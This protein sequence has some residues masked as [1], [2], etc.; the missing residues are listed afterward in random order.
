MAMTRSFFI[1]FRNVL[2]AALLGMACMAQAQLLQP[3]FST[4]FPPIPVGDYRTLSVGVRNPNTRTAW[5]VDFS[6]S[7]A[8]PDP[9]AGTF[10][11]SG[12]CGSS[13]A[14]GGSS[15]VV[16]NMNVLANGF[17]TL[18]FLATGSAAGHYP[19]DILVSNP[20]GV[21]V[22]TEYV[23]VYA[24]PT[25]IAAFSSSPVQVNATSTLTFTIS[26]TDPIHNLSV[27]GSIGLGALVA[28]TV[29]TTCTNLDSDP[30]IDA[31]NNNLIIPYI[32]LATQASCDVS[33]EVRSDTSGSYTVPAGG[34]TSPTLTGTMTSPLVIE[35]GFS[36]AFDISTVTLV[37]NPPAEAIGVTKSFASS[38]VPVG[39]PSTLTIALTN[40]N[41][42]PITGVAFTDSLP[43]GL[44]VATVPSLT[45]TCGGTVTAGP[46][47]TS[48]VLSG[49]TIAAADPP[50]PAAR[51]KAAKALGGCTV[52]IAV[53]ASVPSAGLVN[54]LPAG[55]VTSVE[56]QASGVLSA[57]SSATLVVTA[58]PAVLL[59]PASLSFAQ[60]LL[61][62]TSAVQAVTLTN[63]GS[64]ALAISAIAISGDFAQSNNCGTGIAEGASCQFIVTFTPTASGSR[65]GVLTITDNA[66][67]SPR[68]VALFG[69]GGAVQPL[70][71][72]WAFNPT[73]VVVGNPARLLLT[74]SNPNGAPFMAASNFSQF[75]PVGL[76]LGG[77]PLSPASP[78]AG[79][80]NP[81]VGGP[82]SGFGVS[83]LS[84]PTSGA[85]TFEVDVVSTTLGS[86]NISTA[87]GAITGSVLAEPNVTNVASNT[88]TLVVNPTPA[89]VLSL[90]PPPPG[91]LGFGPVTV[92]TDSSPLN[93]KVANAGNAPLTLNLPFA[94]TGDF[95]NTAT[96]CGTTLATPPDPLSSCT[97]TLVFRPT[98]VGP[99]SGTLAVSSNGGNATLNLAGEGTPTAVPAISVSVGALQFPSQT[100]GTTSPPQTIKV[101]NGGTAPLQVAGVS[102]SGDFAIASGCTAA[103]PLAPSAACVI[104]VTFT[105]ILPGGRTGLVTIISN[106]P[107]SPTTTVALT[108]TGAALPAP[109]ASVT[110][111]SLTFPLQIVGT[112]GSSREVT[113]R[114]TGGSSLTIQS[115]E[116]V[117]T[118]FV[119]QSACPAKLAVGAN[120]N[121]SVAFR[122]D[123]IGYV[124]ATLRFV[125]DAAAPVATVALSGSSRS[126]PQ[127]LLSAAPTS[128]AFGPQII[129]TTSA[130]QSFTVRNVGEATATISQFVSTGDFRLEGICAELAP[131]EACTFR[132][133][134]A[135][136][137]VGELAGQITFTSNASNSPFVVPLSGRGL[138]LPEPQVLLSASSLGFGNSIVGIGAGQA[139]KLTN[140]GTAD[141]KLGLVK[142][143]GDAFSIRSGCTGSLVPGQ[144]CTI[145]VN[146][147]PA[148]A[149]RYAGQLS[150][151]SNAS[152]SPDAVA[153]SGA[154]CRFALAGRNYSLVCAP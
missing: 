88:A 126:V 46:G 138:P 103:S 145:D 136:T 53:V 106:D 82:Q 141:L 135:P 34:A 120:C 8:W 12:D 17:C 124:A 31:L 122:P 58:A 114:N 73:A 108:G 139:I 32:G 146:F 147:Q 130:Q 74:I 27:N 134:F 150:I 40:P 45:N 35:G 137:K 111:T 48:V 121:V 51:G 129:N 69:T 15:G 115:V 83:G 59:T 44:A 2:L 55:A 6:M 143:T 84:V 133:A 5:Q 151:A 119:F 42:Y 20:I 127:A 18:T 64:A 152:S 10:G 25:V 4:S 92:A 79:M 153:L 56:T 21:T 30:Y 98:V 47:A 110:P 41:V 26:N 132:V 24:P 60:Q 117:G 23:D 80:I 38:S 19:L 100:V 50:L 43:A 52:T 7:F 109:V 93:V 14:N 13:S 154:G 77:N 140:G 81:I 1:Q 118:G 91:P 71:V 9:G 61:G 72:N 65:T 116:L 112:L 78:C 90:D 67:G 16:T 57:L 63:T 94:V 148:L 87:G 75:F 37:V 97:V 96:T 36:V 29:L 101:S 54:I 39:T 95:I 104:D 11:F 22:P 86:Y 144:S 102:V 76:G 142:V 107:A 3:T 62:V 125:T 70:G 68:T 89:P 131:A 105:P 49:G 85:C 66:A 28:G 149:E 99:R 113:L 128:V 33:V 123:R